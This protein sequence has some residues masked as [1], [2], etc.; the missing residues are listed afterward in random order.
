MTATPI[1][2]TLA[3]TLYGDLEVSILDEMPPGRTPV[4]T[5]WLSTTRQEDAYQFVRQQVA[6]GRQAYVVCPLIEESESLQAEAA[7]KLAEDLQHGAFADL[8]VALLHGSMKVME[9]DEV[10]EAF[11]R[12]EVDVLVCTTVVE[13][14][15]DVPNAT[16]MLILN[17]ERF[18]LAQLHQPGRAGRGRGDASP[19]S[20]SRTRSTIRRA[21]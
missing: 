6:E 15:V 14:G 17:A 2:R 13:V 11:R 12:G 16:V 3:L 10:M 9:K 21:G 18:G 20:C 1:P 19:V 7:T 5:A 8:R 4:S